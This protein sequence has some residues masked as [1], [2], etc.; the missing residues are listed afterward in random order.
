MTKN[1]ITANITIPEIIYTGFEKNGLLDF[2]WTED[3]FSD[4]FGIIDLILFIIGMEK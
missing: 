2:N 3:L 4:C 1:K